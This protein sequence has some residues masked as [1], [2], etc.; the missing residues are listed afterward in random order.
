MGRSEGR[1][2]NLEA[3]AAVARAVATP[4]QV[5][6]GIDGP[7][8]I[9]LAFAAGATRV[10]MPLWAVAEDPDVLAAACAS[11]ATGSRS[12]ST[13]ATERLARAIRGAIAV[14]RTLDELVDELAGR[15]GAALR[16]VARRRRVPDLELHRRLA[17]S[18]DAGIVVA[19]G[20]DRTATLTG[21]QRAPAPT[22]VIL[23]RGALRRAGLEPSP[24]AS[25]RRQ[26]PVASRGP[27]GFV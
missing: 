22:A 27:Q 3:I 20:V 12:A 14:R 25:R 11:R 24:D 1:P 5:A 7:E 19:G 26:R 17:A 16:P 2:A 8:Q 13:R 15:R 23:G 10:V 18:V 6:G 9:E 21:L 4:L